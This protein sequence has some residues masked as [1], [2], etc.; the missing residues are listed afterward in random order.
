M[1]DQFPLYRIHVHVMKL[2]DE[3]SLT[4]D[5]EIV[6]AKLPELRQRAVWLPKWEWELLGGNFF[7]RLAAEPPRN[8]LLQDL[9]DG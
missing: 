7:A 3:L 1:N 6:K 9:H 5:I 4:P 8:A 2:L